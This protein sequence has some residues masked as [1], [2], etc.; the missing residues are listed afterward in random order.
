MNFEEP[1]ITPGYFATLRQ[2]LLVG[3]RIH[4][5]RR[6]RGSPRW[7]SSISPSP[8][9]STVR[10]R[11]RS[12]ARIGDGGGND[13][14]I[15]TTIVGVVGDIRHQNLRTDM[16]AAVYRPYLQ[17]EASRRRCRSTCAPPRPPKTVEAAIRQAI[18]QLDPTLVVDGLR[19]MD[20][21]G[22]SQRLR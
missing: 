21:A 12:V 19:T 22:R 10:R 15:D 18:H 14:K 9:D 7:R 4:A 5:R 20:E 6:A 13:T 11:T 3:P 1:R 17:D 16:G 8:S 2:P